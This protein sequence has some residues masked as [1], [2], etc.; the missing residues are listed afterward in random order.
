MKNYHF[1]LS[2]FHTMYTSWFQYTWVL[3]DICDLSKLR[4]HGNNLLFISCLEL[5]IVINQV[6]QGTHK[7]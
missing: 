3:Y 1:S 4:L 2:M 5:D 6:A 7:L